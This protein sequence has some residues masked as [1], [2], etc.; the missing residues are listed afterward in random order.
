M[1]QKILFRPGPGAYDSVVDE[2][3]FYTTSEEQKPMK[4]TCPY[5]RQVD[6]HQIRWRKCVKKSALPP[7]ASPEDRV[8]FQKARAHMVRIDDKV[9][10]K[11]PRCRRPFEIPSLQSVVLL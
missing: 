6:E 4:M 10:C 5:C 9:S 1:T 8:R 2:R 11:N 3:N 7:G